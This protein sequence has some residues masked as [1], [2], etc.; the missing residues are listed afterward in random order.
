MSKSMQVCKALDVFALKR[1]KKYPFLLQALAI[2]VVLQLLQ[3]L[4]GQIL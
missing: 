2:G 3:Q 4:C 1:L